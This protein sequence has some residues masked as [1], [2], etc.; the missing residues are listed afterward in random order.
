MESSFFLN[1]VVSK[2]PAILKL[3]SSENEPLLIRWDSFFVLNF[4]LD[5]FDRVRWLHVKSDS[6][7]SESLDED[8]HS[9]SES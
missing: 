6:F 1:V 7:A 9:S 3:F 2:C 8:L 4:S 5:I